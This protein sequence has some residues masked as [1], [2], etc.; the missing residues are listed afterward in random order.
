MKTTTLL[1]VI[2]IAVAFAGPAHAIYKC[3]TPKGVLYQDR[4]CSEGNEADLQ[5]VIPTGQTAP[6]IQAAQEIGSQ[7]AVVRNESRLGAAKIGRT[8][9]EDSASLT[10]PAD[11]RANETAVNT[12]TG[13]GGA[14]TSNDARKKEASTTVDNSGMASPAAEQARNADPSAKYFTTEGFSAGAETPAHMTCE[15]AN[16][17]K[18]VFYLN[19]GKLTSI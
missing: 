5:L 4:P 3:T 12:K 8:G 19:N 10:K 6:K 7:A 15:S 2:L 9:K 16:G 18:R 17:E 14:N 13:E 1:G 11:K